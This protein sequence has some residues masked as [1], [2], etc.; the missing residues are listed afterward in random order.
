M[1]LLNL[2]KDYRRNLLAKKEKDGDGD[3][4]PNTSK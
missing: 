4:S 1:D 2:D 3:R